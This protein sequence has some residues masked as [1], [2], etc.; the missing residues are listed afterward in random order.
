MPEFNG[1]KEYYSTGSIQ[2]NQYVPI[3]SFTFDRKPSRANR[4]AAIDDVFQAKM[5]ETNK[6]IIVDEQLDGKLFSTG[7]LQLRPYGNT[8][9]PRFLYFYVISSL[10]LK[11]KDELATGSTQEALTDTNAVK[12]VF[13][14]PPLNEQKRITAK[15]NKIIPRIDAVRERFEKVP[16]IIKRFRQSVL[17]IAVTG[18]LTEKWREEHPDVEGAEINSG[19]PLGWK[20]KTISEIALKEKGAIQSGPF[21]SQLLHSEFQDEGILAIG[22]DNVQDGFFSKGKEHRISA[23]KYRELIKFTAKPLDVLITVMSTV[24]R[25]CVIPEYIEK[26]IITKHV[27]RISCDQKIAN[28]YYILSV[29]RG[30][31][32]VLDA[33]SEQTRGATRPGINGT[34]IKTLEVPLPPLEEQQEI[35]RQRD[36]LFAI[37]DKVEAHCKKAKA[38]V[39]KLTQ[40]V[41]AKAFRG[42]LVPQNPDDEPAKKLLERIKMEKA[43]MTTKGKQK[44][45][46]KTIKSAESFKKKTTTKP[47]NILEIL[48]DSKNP[49]DAKELW[50]ESIH[51]DDIEAF[52]A[53]LKKIENQIEE[54]RDGVTSKLRLK[55]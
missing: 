29:L 44:I 16:T 40:S 41:L 32:I 53:E 10:F 9:W 33:I 21:G 4:I 36:R 55:K 13:P 34:V 3:G 48:M 30:A 20:I 17:T 15:L 28:P 39:E 25:C 2:G 24:G 14:L 38:K 6:G 1:K 42:E 8:Y 27:Y 23:S 7:F 51:K 37:A 19:L 22:I 11:Q 12:L 50:Q 46:L 52:Y 26:S 54:I 49:L 45:R 43:N 5:K 31:K 35:V 18:K 47:K